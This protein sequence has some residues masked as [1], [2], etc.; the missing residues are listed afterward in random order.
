MTTGT[1]MPYSDVGGH[2]EQTDGQHRVGVALGEDERDQ[3][4][5]PGAEPG[6]DAHYTEHR[7]C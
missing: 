1:S 5:V 2:P 7:P 4:V 3:E 6:E